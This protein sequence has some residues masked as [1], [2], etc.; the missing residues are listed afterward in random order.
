MARYDKVDSHSS[1]EPPSTD[2]VLSLSLLE[3]DDAMLTD[4]G[5]G[6]GVTSAAK[7]ADVRQYPL[8]LLPNSISRS[9]ELDLRVFPADMWDELISE[10]LS[11]RAD[12]SDKL[13]RYRHDIIGTTV[14]T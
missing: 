5:G 6:G 1:I 11:N 9:L 8:L 7:A 13:S 10:I 2:E 14:H 4:T 3:P 12:V